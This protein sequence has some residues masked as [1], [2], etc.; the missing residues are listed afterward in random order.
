MDVTTQFDQTQFFNQLRNRFPR[1]ATANVERS[2]WGH[3]EY[4]VYFGIAVQKLYCAALGDG[5]YLGHK[6]FFHLVHDGAGRWADGGFKIEG[7]KAHHNVSIGMVLLVNLFFARTGGLFFA[8]LLIAAPFQQGYLRGDGYFSNN[9]VFVER[10]ICGVQQQYYIKEDGKK[11]MY[12]S[13]YSD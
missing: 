7:M 3:A 10:S 6:S 1:L 8:V 4:V 9:L 5:Q 2:P 12:D 13:G 11:C